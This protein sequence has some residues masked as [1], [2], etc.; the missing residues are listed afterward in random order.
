M[1][2]LGAL[3]DLLGVASL[4]GCLSCNAHRISNL[5]SLPAHRCKQV[6]GDFVPPCEDSLKASPSGQITRLFRRREARP[7]RRYIRYMTSTLQS[8]CSQTET[9]PKTSRLQIG[10]GF[11]ALGPAL[12]QLLSQPSCKAGAT[13]ADHWLRVPGSNIYP[14]PDIQQLHLRR[15]AVEDVDGLDPT[16]GL[17]CSRLLDVASF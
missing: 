9:D 3:Q 5:K 6:P 15:F 14:E 11:L 2:D 13:S 8:P 7:L 10:L 16:P 4:H 17:S 12:F 1:Q